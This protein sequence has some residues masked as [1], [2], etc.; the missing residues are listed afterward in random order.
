[1]C[2][3]F[4]HGLEGLLSPPELASGRIG[5][6][7]SRAV[8]HRRPK[9]AGHHDDRRPRHGRLQRT[10]DVGSI[11]SDHRLKTYLDAQGA[12]FIRDE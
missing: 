9:A 8:V 5:D 10:N 12:Q 4:L 7:L 1:L 3:P 11:V 2:Q 6:G